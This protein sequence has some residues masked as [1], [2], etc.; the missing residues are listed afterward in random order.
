MA[1]LTFVFSTIQLHLIMTFIKHSS[2]LTMSVTSIHG[3]LPSR[4]LWDICCSL[5]HQTFL[6]YTTR[7]FHN[8]V[9]FLLWPSNLVLFPELLMSPLTLLPSSPAYWTPSSLGAHVLV[10]H[11][12]WTLA[13]LKGMSELKWM[14][15]SQFNS[16]GHCEQSSARRNEI[17]FIVNRSQNAVSWCSLRN[18]RMIS[19]R[20]QG[21]PSN[22]TIVKGLTTDTLQRL[23]LTDFKKTYRPF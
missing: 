17:V 16:D 19:V 9:S 5:Q 8:W 12:Y 21:K 11:L 20:F 15:I 23:K 14:G 3:S 18:H 7:Y 22:I 2:C 6:F 1:S 4:F 13:R 10:P